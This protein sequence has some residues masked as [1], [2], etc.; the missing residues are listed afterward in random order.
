MV[1]D[2]MDPPTRRSHCGDWRHPPSPST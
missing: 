1:N 2:L